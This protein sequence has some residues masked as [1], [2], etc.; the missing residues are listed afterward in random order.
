VNFRAAIILQGGWFEPTSGKTLPMCHATILFKKYIYAMTFYNRSLHD[1][2]LHKTFYVIN[3][4]EHIIV[5]V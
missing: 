5:L 1:V 4:G 2:K 3:D